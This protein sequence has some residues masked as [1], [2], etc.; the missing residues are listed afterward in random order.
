[1][2]IGSRFYIE[3]F[4]RWNCTKSIVRINVFYDRHYNKQSEQLNKECDY[5]D[6]KLLT[7]TIYKH[8]SSSFDKSELFNLTVL[9]PLVY[10]H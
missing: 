2:F 3:W 10:V 6:T 5:F 8:V 9:T 4:E 1:M 7:Q